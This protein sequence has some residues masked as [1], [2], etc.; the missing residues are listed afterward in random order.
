M[1]ASSIPT[2]IKAGLIRGIPPNND[3]PLHSNLLGLTQEEMLH[4]VFSNLFVVPDVRINTLTWKRWDIFNDTDYT[5]KV[6]RS[7]PEC[8]KLLLKDGRCFLCEPCGNG[9]YRALMLT[10]TLR[11]TSLKSKITLQEALTICEDKAARI[12]NQKRKKVKPFYDK[13]TALKPCPSISM[14][15]HP[16]FEGREALILAIEELSKKMIA[17]KAC[18]VRSCNSFDFEKYL[19][20]QIAL[21]TD[22]TQSLD[23]NRRKEILVSLREYGCSEKYFDIFSA[24][25]LREVLQY[26]A[27]IMFC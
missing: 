13:R 23:I 6:V 15:R 22:T 11:P 9:L 26:K 14:I 24:L 17:R 7:H 5:W 20:A 18:W 25:E 27:A 21:D 10:D 16:F 2:L 19:Y 1:S 12:E 4:A 8:V 3:L